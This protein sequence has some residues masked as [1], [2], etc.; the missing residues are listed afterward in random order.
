MAPAG[1]G[2][3]IAAGLIVRVA[4]L[5]PLLN[6]GRRLKDDA[7]RRR[8]RTAHGVAYWL[9]DMA[10]IGGLMF[11]LTAGAVEGTINLLAAAFIAL[12]V[13]WPRTMEEV[14]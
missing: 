7:D 8:Y 12:L 1:S 9:V 5:K 11:G 14:A 13:M 10:G 2:A 6:R 4:W 3:L